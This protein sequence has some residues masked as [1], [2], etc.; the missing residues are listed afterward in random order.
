MTRARRRLQLSAAP[1][2]APY[3]RSRGRVSRFLGEIPRDLLDTP[4]GEARTIPI[5]TSPAAGP[6]RKGDTVRHRKFGV[7]RVETV[8]PDGTRLSVLFRVHGRKRLVLEYA[9]LE[10][11]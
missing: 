7:G 3:L 2:G 9:R 10:R 8:D 1:G 5:A 6:F 11:V 4:R